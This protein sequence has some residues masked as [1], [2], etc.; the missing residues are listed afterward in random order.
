MNAGTCLS[1]HIQS[2]VPSW[3]FYLIGAKVK[4]RTQ[5]R[6][7]KLRCDEKLFWRKHQKS[8]EVSMGLGDLSKISKTFKIG[9]LVWLALVRF[10]FRKYF[11]RTAS[12]KKPKNISSILL[13]NVYKT[14]RSQFTV[15]FHLAPYPN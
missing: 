13:N 6:K 12:L 1:L 2:T 5:S 8:L 11:L 3:I 14:L 9:Y 7:K 10:S 4:K 15:M